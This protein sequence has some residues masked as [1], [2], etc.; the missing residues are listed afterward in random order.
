MRR[1][2]REQ[3]VNLFAFQ[4]IITGVAGVML[5]ILLLLVVQLS[6]RLAT[7]AAE[8]QEKLADES[9]K[10]AAA[11]PPPDEVMEDPFQDLE[12]LGTDRRSSAGSYFLGAGV[13]RITSGITQFL[14][15]IYIYIY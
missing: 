15:N 13:G 3:T 10:A 11:T 4:D 14:N 1:R 8:L 2:R 6:L 9:S 12:Q 5:F 7:Q